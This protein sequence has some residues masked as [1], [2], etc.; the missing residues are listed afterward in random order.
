M[1]SILIPLN[2]TYEDDIILPSITGEPQKDLPILL[3]LSKHELLALCENDTYVFKL[4]QSN[5][6][7]YN[8]ITSPKALT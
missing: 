2:T 4:C 8:I 1:T 7:L 3:N 6:I 5:S